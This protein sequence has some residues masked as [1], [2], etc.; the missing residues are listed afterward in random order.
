MARQIIEALIDDL[1]GSKADETVSFGFDGRMYE[2]D[3]SYANAAKLRALVDPW[4]EKARKTGRAGAR[5]SATPRARSASGDGQLAAI[6]TWAAEN[7]HRVSTRGRISAEVT[8][9][10]RA[11][12]EAPEA[13]PVEAAKAP[14]A[15]SKKPAVPSFV[16]PAKKTAKKTGKKV[17]AGV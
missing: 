7:G 10:Y 13:A 17:A 6:R 3:L 12:H 8:A 14:A 4:A 11:A 15:N 16:E 2:I 1:D 9:A 5:A